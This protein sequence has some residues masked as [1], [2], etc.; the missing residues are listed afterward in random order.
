[1]FTKEKVLAFAWWLTVTG[2]VTPLATLFAINTLFKLNI[3]V[4]FNTW[5][6]I[7][8]ITSWIEALAYKASGK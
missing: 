5:L 7:A 2:I 1:M 3:D 8:V 4:N 6:A